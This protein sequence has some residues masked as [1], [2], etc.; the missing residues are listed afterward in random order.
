MIVLNAK[1]T[2]ISLLNIIT[3]LLLYLFMKTQLILNIK[4]LWTPK[5]YFSFVEKNL[6]N[7]C[8]LYPFSH[9]VATNPAPAISSNYAIQTLSIIGLPNLAHLKIWSLIE[10]LKMLIK[11]W[12]IFALSSLSITLHVLLTPL[13]G[14]VSSKS[15]IVIL[16]LTTVYFYRM[17]LKL[18]I[19]NSNL[20]LCSQCYSFSS[21]QTFFLS[22]CFP[23]TALVIL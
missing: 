19:S 16:K 13:E 14:M 5:T 15:K 18:V 1:R 20:C 4:D 6:L 10:V 11:I 7:V 22:N 12:P 23:Y 17:V 9:F 8:N 3:F 21:T 2:N